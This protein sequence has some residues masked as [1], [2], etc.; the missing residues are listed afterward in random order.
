MRRLMAGQFFGSRLRLSLFAHATESASSTLPVM[1]ISA[2]KVASSAAVAAALGACLMGCGS[3]SSPTPTG[4]SAVPSAAVTSTAKASPVAAS[5][6]VLSVGQSGVYT[7]TDSADDHTTQMQV[8]VVGVKYVTPAEVDTTN[9]PKGRY[10]R[11]T[12]TIKDVGKAS[13]SYSSYGQITWEDA[14]MAA[15]DA[16]TLEGIG[17]GPDLDTT[18]KPGQSVTGSVVLDV[19]RKG[20]TLVYS[21]NPFAGKASFSVKLPAA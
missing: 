2:R 20:G 14:T 21:D 5:A 12:L 9:K 15:Q 13:G 18:Y 1:D 16:T 3:S 11:L 8:T 4:T 7:A 10:V 19:V 17:N 6:P